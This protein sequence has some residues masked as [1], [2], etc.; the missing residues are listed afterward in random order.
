MLAAIAVLSLF[1]ILGSAVVQ[2]RSPFALLA[3]WCVYLHALEILTGEMAQG[4]WARRGRWGE[5]FE[6]AKRSC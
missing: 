6:R 1:G 3:F 4:A 5:C 2:K